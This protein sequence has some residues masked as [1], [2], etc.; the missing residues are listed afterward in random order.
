MF[1][2]VQILIVFAAMASVFLGTSANAQHMGSNPKT[3]AMGHSE[4]NSNAPTPPEGSDL[5]GVQTKTP[6]D[7]TLPKTEFTLL[8]LDRD[9]RVLDIIDPL[10]IRAEHSG[11]IHLTGLDIPDYNPY[12]QGAIAQSAAVILRDMM[13]GKTVKLYQTRDREAGRKNRMNQSLYHLVIKDSDSWVQGILVRLGLAR[14]RTE[15]S[16]PEMAR[17]L[18]AL[19]AE[20]RAQKLGLWAFEQYAVLTPE[21]TPEHL[22][23]FAIVEGT[24][25]SAARKQ[26]NIYL[27]FGSDWRNDFTIQIK[28]IHS[29]TFNAGGINPLDL[30]GKTIRVRGWLQSYNGPYIEIDHPERI[31]IL[32]P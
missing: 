3:G 8:R 4:R 11:I 30:N 27:N 9:D 21:Q 28:P 26:N 12:S 6:E 23:S 15:P 7:I 18:Y 32:S 16:N 31:E 20:A 22:N 19:E 10:T 14:V 29:R 24:V 5:P 2:F 25:M 17:E 1:M 13:Q